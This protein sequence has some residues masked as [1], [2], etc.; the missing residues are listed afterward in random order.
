MSFLNVLEDYEKLDIDNILKETTKA[1]II[2]ILKKESLNEV[3]FLKLLSPVAENF[4]EPMANRAH[5]KTLN[6]FGKTILLYTPM[7]LSNYCVN[8]CVYCSFNND[9]NI[10]RSKLTYEEIEIEAKNISKTG[11]KH[12]L[13]LTGESRKATPMEY[14]EKSIDILKKYFESISIEI[15]PL[16][17]HEYE[18]LIKRGVDGLTIYQEVYD[19]SIY[20]KVHISGPKADYLYR[21]DAPER[22]CNKKIRT[23]NIGPLLGLNDFRKESFLAG[24]H[25]KYLQKKYLDTEISMSFPRIRPF[26]GGYKEILEVSDKNY[27]QSILAFKNFMPESGITLSTR[28]SKALRDNLIPLGITK[29]SAGVKTS[30]G[31]YSKD[32]SIDQFEISDNRSVNQMKIDIEKKGY[33]PIFNDWLNKFNQN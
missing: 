8:N 7:Y 32:D 33:Q 30:V 6:H 2:D 11:I 26:V 12:I 29:M 21:L 9:N 14:L 24:V 23:V 25:A 20:K 3:D 17:D 5:N 19:K 16:E 31:G 28:E 27:V 13:I 4:L 22:A 10:K 15:Y 18:S 1:D